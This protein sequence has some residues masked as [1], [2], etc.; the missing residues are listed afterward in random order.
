MAI[1]IGSILHGAYGDYYEQAVCLRHLAATRPGTRLELFFAS[2]HRRRELEVLDWSFAESLH[3]WTEFPAVALDEVVQFQVGDDELGPQVLDKLPPEAQARIDRRH[4]RLP[5]HTLRRI[6]P[7]PPQLQLGLSDAGRAKMRAILAGAGV[8]QDVFA[9]RPTVAFLWRQRAAGGYIREL[10]PKDPQALAAKYSRALRRLIDA[11]GCHVFV[12]GMN[13][14]TTDENRHR[15]DAKFAEFGLDL[16]AAHAT[17]LPGASW[18]AEL[19]IACRCDLV[20]G[21]PSGFTEAAYVRR[22]GDV[23]LLDPPL[24]Y[25]AV[26]TRHRMPLFDYLT[27]GGFAR[28][29][30]P[31][32]EDRIVR[33]ISRRLARRGWRPAAR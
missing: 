17:H 1:T 22:P 25:L 20:V 29:W 27:P 4:H 9:A 14:K 2:E 15:V 26:M 12:A 5:W 23:L 21:N 19:E 33:W 18:G 32:D 30:L 13:V 3:A 7:L 10:R 24:H 6:L 28:A 31:H 11:W 16:P 8:G